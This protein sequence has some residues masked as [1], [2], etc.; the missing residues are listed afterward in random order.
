M[1]VDKRITPHDERLYRA[2]RPGLATS[3][4]PA[5]RRESGSNAISDIGLRSDSSD[6]GETP[7]VPWCWRSKL[8]SAL[9]A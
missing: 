7:P 9:I 3:K 2:K 6:D 5:K 8:L 1:L 4:D